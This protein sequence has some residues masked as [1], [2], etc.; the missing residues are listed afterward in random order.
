MVDRESAVSIFDSPV[1]AK[2]VVQELRAVVP[3]LRKCLSSAYTYKT[4]S[5]VGLRV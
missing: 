1:Q 4:R 5:I 3:T 2:V